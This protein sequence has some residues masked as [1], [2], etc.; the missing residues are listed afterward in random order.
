M[1]K[2]WLYVIVLAIILLSGCKTSK[3]NDDPRP[4]LMDTN[5]FTNFIPFTNDIPL[6]TN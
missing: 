3:N 1:R 4:P 5:S 6:N 2:T